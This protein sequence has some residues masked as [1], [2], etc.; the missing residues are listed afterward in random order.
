[1]NIPNWMPHHQQIYLEVWKYKYLAQKQLCHHAKYFIKIAK[2]YFT[3]FIKIMISKINIFNPSFSA[4]NV[5]LFSV[6]R[7]P[8]TRETFENL[9]NAW[10]NQGLVYEGDTLIIIPKNNLPEAAKYD[11]KI[12]ATLSKIRLSDN[13]FA[14]S[15]MTDENRVDT[16]AL[17]Y[18][19]PK[20]ITILGL[21][22]AIRNNKNYFIQLDP[23]I[24][25]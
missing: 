21:T 14:V 24:V 22:N 4:N 23:I 19:D 6:R 10:S 2:N 9:A 1:M 15:V 8:V 17:Q 5:N 7:E 11:K 20:V 18:F 13:G 12:A 16:R 25:E 3:S